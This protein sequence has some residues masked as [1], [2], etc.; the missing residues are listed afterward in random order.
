[1]DGGAEGI[2][3]KAQFQNGPGEAW[4]RYFGLGSAANLL[5]VR[6]A[7]ASA[8]CCGVNLADSTVGFAGLK[9]GLGVESQ[10]VVPIES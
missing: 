10:Q 2:D 9:R 3:G 4:E 1:M 7:E 5:E 6:L 8:T